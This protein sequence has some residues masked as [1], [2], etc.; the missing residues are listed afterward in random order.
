VKTNAIKY[1]SLG[2]TKRVHLVGIGGAGMSAIAELLLKRGFEV[3]GSDQQ[4]SEITERLKALGATV[5]IGHNKDII[6]GADVVRIFLG[7]QS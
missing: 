5:C 4:R 2:R 1:S 7:G 6:E 3:S